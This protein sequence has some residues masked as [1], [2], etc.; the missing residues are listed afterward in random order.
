MLSSLSDHCVCLQPN[1]DS[2]RDFEFHPPK[3]EDMQVGV[4]LYYESEDD[5][6]YE[7]ESNGRRSMRARQRRTPKRSSNDQGQSDSRGMTM[8]VE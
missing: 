8:S 1:R 3:P 7:F 4:R 2:V 6:G 5:E